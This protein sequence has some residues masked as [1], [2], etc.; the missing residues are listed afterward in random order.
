MQKIV[1][2]STP[3]LQKWIFSASPSSYSWGWY[4]F[5][6]IKFLLDDIW[7]KRTFVQRLKKWRNP[8]P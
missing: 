1:V 7:L 6:E 8:L 2:F 5:G 4:N 3:K